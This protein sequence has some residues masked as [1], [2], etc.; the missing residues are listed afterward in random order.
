MVSIDEAV[1][2]IR[3]AWPSNGHYLADLQDR[4]G[5]HYRVVESL[6]SCALMS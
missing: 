5:D 3:V 2:Q 6:R 4:L 1:Q